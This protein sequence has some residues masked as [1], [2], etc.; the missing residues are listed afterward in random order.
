MSLRH[1]GNA[2]AG[3]VRLCNNRSPFRW[4][5]PYSFTPSKPTT[6]I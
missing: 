5:S 1:I 6:I 4:C 3:V 2:R